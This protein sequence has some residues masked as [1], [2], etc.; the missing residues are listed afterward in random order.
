M[1]IC[2]PPLCQ[3]LRSR[4]TEIEL[5]ELT[6][7]LE[8]ICADRQ[9]VLGG[10]LHNSDRFSNEDLVCRFFG[11]E[12]RRGGRA[13]GGDLYGIHIPQHVPRVLNYDGGRLSNRLHCLRDALIVGGEP[14]GRLVRYGRT[15]RRR[16]VRGSGASREHRQSCLSDAFTNQVQVG[17]F[18]RHRLG[19]LSTMWVATLAGLNYETTAGAGGD[20]L[21]F[22]AALRISLHDATTE[23]FAIWAEEFC[24][25]TA[26]IMNSDSE[27]A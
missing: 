17:S 13:N 5:F 14:A 1:T 21:A 15:P 8:S 23:A 2:V 20:G 9:I 4:Q 26:L 6:Q 27:Y 3:D 12:P 24:V 11:C 16:S 10:F 25:D 19:D 18:D 22:A 7:D